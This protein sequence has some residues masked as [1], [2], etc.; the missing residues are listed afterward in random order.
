MAPFALDPQCEKHQML[1]RKA[2]GKN[3]R[4]CRV[5][6]ET[7]AYIHSYLHQEEDESVRWL[8]TNTTKGTIVCPSHQQWSNALRDSYD[9]FLNHIPQEQWHLKLEE[10]RRSGI[11][12]RGLV[13]KA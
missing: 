6:R 12:A 7:W 5:C 10:L 4:I 8:E 9:V 2:W 13:L 1:A 3:R 11:L